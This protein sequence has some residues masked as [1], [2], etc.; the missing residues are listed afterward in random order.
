MSSSP[1]ASRIFALDIGT[2][3]VIGLVG[4]L[5]EDGVFF[6]ECME[7]E[8]Y[9]TRAVVDGQIEDIAETG[10]IVGVVKSRLEA[11]L[12]E[13]LR[14]VCIAAAGRTLSTAGAASAMEVPEGPIT[15]EFV[16][17]LE[18]A[19]V[20]VAQERLCSADNALFCV[21]HAVRGYA[22]DGYAMSSLLE[23]R[24]KVAEAA[25]IATFLPREVVDSLYAVT[26]RAGLTV[27]ALTLEPIAAMNAVIPA[28]L[29]R[30]NLALVDIGAGTADI[31]LC[32]EGG[33]SAYAMSTMAGDELTEA[34]MELCL[35]DFQTA[36]TVKRAMSAGGIVSYTDILGFP[37]E[38]ESAALLQKLRPTLESLS[39]ELCRR[40]TE[41]NGAS[42]AAVFLV[43]GGSMTPG[44]PALV[45]EGL[46]LPENRVAVGGSNYMTR[47]IRSEVPLT[48]PDFATP[49][50]IALTAAER[51][52]A[53]AFSVTV[54]GEPLRLAGFLDTTVLGVLQA[55]GIRRGQMLGARGHDL[56]VT[57]DGAR[58][59]YRGESATPAS[60]TRNGLTAALGD[61][62][63]RGDALVFVSAVSGRDA[64]P[65]LGQVL[66]AEGA[67]AALVNGLSAERGR[68]LREGDE[69]TL[70]HSD[71]STSGLP[72]APGALRVTLNG[73][74]LTLEPRS[75][76]TPYQFFDL[77]SYTDIDPSHP[78]GNIIQRLN[79]VSSSYVEPLCD[80]DTAEIFWQKDET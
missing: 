64:T 77:L 34:V 79:G 36:E 17:R 67:E 41:L 27:A 74:M 20:Q 69:I 29:R 32:R 57:V 70:L 3:S 31:A 50:G 30:L 56:S 78:E 40:I 68:L 18:L 37:H 42:P 61:Q 65:N 73:R 4:H 49:V 24:G 21:G 25:V 60:I 62:V 6:T 23:H 48:G 47:R 59:V 11:Q 46:N 76:G 66:T 8:E 80:G 72:P 2:R 54:N 55:S 1:D 35:T 63:A 43:G 10:R 15:A 51:L 16:S 12:G 9:Q 58:R 45:A 71:L 53:D 19:A 38:E 22:L 14:R 5:E 39:A 26:E 13:P 75:N 7:R 52:S 28:D 33:I 44:L